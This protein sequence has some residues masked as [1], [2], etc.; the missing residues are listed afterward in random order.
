MRKL[1]IVGDG[2]FAEIAYEYFTADSDYEV[3]GFAVE[4]T[5]LTRESCCGLPVVPF[6]HVQHKFPPVTHDAFIGVTYSQLNRLRMRFF[7][8]TKEKGYKLASYISSRAFVWRN[9]SLGEN[10]FVFEDNTI[11]HMARIGHNVILWSGNHIGHR[12]VV[13]DHCYLS[14]HVVVSGY[15]IIGEGSFIGVNTTIADRTRVGSDCFVGAGCLIL[16]DTPDGAV[17]KGHH[18]EQSKVSSYR[19]ARVPAKSPG[20]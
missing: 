6:E 12:S 16:K 8:A 11:Q 10:V 13:E 18:A 4:Q 14:S 1:V 15:C 9:V 7:Y 19:F 3:A 5:H 2:E 20:S 17:F